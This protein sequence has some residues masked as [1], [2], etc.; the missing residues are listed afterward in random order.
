MTQQT[1]QGPA[2]KA[3]E[4]VELISRPRWRVGPRSF[5]AVHD[6]EH[7]KLLRRLHTNLLEVSH[8]DDQPEEMRTRVAELLAF[9]P[10]SL[11]LD[12]TAELVDISDQLVIAHGS[13]SHVRGMLAYEDVRDA[14]QVRPTIWSEVFGEPMAEGWPTQAATPLGPGEAPRRMLAA[15]YAARASLYELERA[16]LMQRAYYLLRLV[17]VLIVLVLG[18]AVLIGTI[19]GGPSGQTI[20]AAALAG[21]LGG[22]VSGTFKLRD[23]IAHIGELRAFQPALVVQPLIG[24]AAG[25]FVLAVLE[26][27][28]I[29]IDWGGQ[30]WAE[31]A[32]FAFVAGFSEPFFLG[33]VSRVAAITDDKDSGAKQPPE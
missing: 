32:V 13:E 18:L 1:D 17:P 14:K 12:A 9:E 19:D 30:D 24:A 7:R 23:H 22:A 16:R 4:I 15:L 28:V 6:P 26:S 31:A 10:Q 20:F 25:L 5:R 11:S 2:T 29:D 8:F 21:A 33:V 27:R 3:S